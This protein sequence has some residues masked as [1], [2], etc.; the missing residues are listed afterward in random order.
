MSHLFFK[1]FFKFKILRFF[2]FKSNITLNGKSFIVPLIGENGYS[3]LHISELWMISILKILL[4]KKSGSF[5]DV[6]VNIGQT[7]LK[8]KSVEN[9]RPYFGFEPNSFCVHY[10]SEL[11]QL[12]NFKNTKLFPFGV[13][14]KNEIGVLNFYSTGNS[15][16]SASMI[17]N[18]RPDQKIEKR[19]YIPLYA[20]LAFSELMGD[21]KIGF[22]KID[23]EGAELEVLESF[24]AKIAKDKPMILIEILPVYNKSNNSRLERQM[25]IESILKEE[26]YRL[27]R[28][29]K[30]ETKVTN[31]KEID[32][33][34]IHSD[35]SASD[36]IYVH[37]VD[38]GIIQSIQ[39]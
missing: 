39:F 10:S 22:L 19:T 11:I 2:N 13:S 26:K 15:D 18:F 29:I 3:N 4:P 6:G 27:F 35:V 20:E 31:L 38:L 37:E 9:N 36:Y 8:L 23:V 16:S 32:S 34:G 1:L 5:V 21:D 24:R 30:S 25:K 33:I 12:N 28:L 17:S 7:L 14:N